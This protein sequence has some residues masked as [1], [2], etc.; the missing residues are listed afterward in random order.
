M[1]KKLYTLNE[2]GQALLKTL[3]DPFS[4]FYIDAVMDLEEAIENE[5][6]PQFEGTIFGGELFDEIKR[7]F[8]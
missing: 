1:A 7:E 2:Q 3:V 8:K 6:M 4:E 5:D